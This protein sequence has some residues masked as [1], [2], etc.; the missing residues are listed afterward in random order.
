M[1]EPEAE[2]DPG[3]Q[4]PGERRASGWRGRGVRDRESNGRDAGQGIQKI[5]GV[6]QW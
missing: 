6:V 4:F 2:I 1:G 5:A 3:D